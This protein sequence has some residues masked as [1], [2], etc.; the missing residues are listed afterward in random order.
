MSEPAPKKDRPP[1]LL[2]LAIAVVLWS[3]SHGGFRMDFALPAMPSLS[4]WWPVS[5]PA[6]SASATELA[7]PIGEKLAD[8]PAKAAAYAQYYRDWADAVERDGKEDAPSIKTTDVFAAAHENGLKLIVAGRPEFAEPAVNPLVDEVI[9]QYLGI[10]EPGG[11]KAV[12]LEEWRRAKLVEVLRAI[13]E[14]CE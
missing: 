10:A 13:S 9:G 1:L 3:A 12:A 11:W 8:N 6:V 14:A 7:A 4:D 2:L 5:Q